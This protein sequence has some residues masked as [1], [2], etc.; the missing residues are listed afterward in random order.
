MCGLF[1]KMQDIT[2]E[3]VQNGLLEKSHKKSGASNFGHAF[4]ALSIPVQQKTFE[5]SL[6]KSGPSNMILTCSIY[7][8][9]FIRRQSKNA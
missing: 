3:N 2:I 9:R 6:M 4:V 5:K 1:N 7:E 8:T